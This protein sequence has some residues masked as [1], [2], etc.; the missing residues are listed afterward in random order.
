MSKNIAFIPL[1]TFS[2]RLRQKNFKNLLDIPVFN[3]ALKTALKS[4]IFCKILLSTDNSKLVKKKLRINDDKIQILQRNKYEQNFNLPIKKVMHSQLSRYKDIKDIDNIC[5]IYSTA[6]LLTVKKLKNSY[7]K[8]SN[9]V[10][11]VMGVS[12]VSPHP[13]RCFS[14]SKGKI[15][16]LVNIKNKDSMKWQK[17]FASNGSICWL[18]F[19]EF[20]KTKS[21]YIE[22]IAIEIFSKYEH[23]DVDIIEDFEFLAKIFKTITQKNKKT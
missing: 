8:L 18:N 2:R 16:K 6:A 5:V 4:K 23:V 17:Y 20:K 13:N 7:R 1:K 9:E 3:Y 11:C 12:S 14:I 21:L 22:P 19:K 10:N 15:T